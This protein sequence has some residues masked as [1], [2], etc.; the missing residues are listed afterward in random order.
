MIRLTRS[1]PI[2]ALAALLAAGCASGPKSSPELADAFVPAMEIASDESLV[3]VI[4]QKTMM[5]AGMPLYV[6][7]DDKIVAD[8][9]AGTYAYFKVKDGIHTVSVEQS[10]PVK[11]LRV[12]RR[13]GEIIFLYFQYDR[14]VFSEVEA[15]LGK[16]LV[17]QLAPCKPFTKDFDASAL[18][19]SLVNPSLVGLD[20]V[21][22]GGP[23]VKPDAES[24]VV[25]FYRAKNL[26][27]N[28]TIAVWSDKEFLGNVQVKSALRAK[29]PAGRHLFYSGV[30]WTDDDMIA[31]LKD[32]SKPSGKNA[33]VTAELT[34]GKEYFVNLEAG[35]TKFG[36]AVVLSA[37]KPD[38]A[39]KSTVSSLKSLVLDGDAIAGSVRDRLDAAIP[40]LEKTMSEDKVKLLFAKGVELKAED[41]SAAD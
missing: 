35:Y 21:K 14:G 3:Y 25:T 5:G 12:D 16:S 11:W 22:A 1:I 33:W 2:A 28:K 26:A 15:G 34:A 23:E 27:S 20:L 32:S 41:G 38:A 7:L 10:T 39:T 29:V 13:A 37:S 30:G 17:M 31:W 8:L 9:K 19:D 24:A 18:A 6:G 4:R 40:E 36:L